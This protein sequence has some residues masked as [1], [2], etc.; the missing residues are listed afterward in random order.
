MLTLTLQVPLT[1]PLEAEVL[2]PDRLIGLTI[3][4]IQ[5]LPLRH[6]NR[7]VHLSDYFT[8]EGEPGDT[9][10]LHGDLSRVKWIGQ[11]MTQGTMQIHGSAGMHLGSGM[12]G[13]TITVQGNAADWT[14]AEMSGGLIRV[15]GNAGHRLGA[16]YTGSPAGMRGGT[17]VVHG[18]TG[19]ETGWQMQRG[20]ILLNGTAGDFTGARM[21]G[22]TIVLTSGAGKRT[23]AG[24]E[25][26]T[27]ISLT[28][29][30]RLPTFL[31]AC[32]YLPQ[33][34]G[35]YAR[36]CTTHGVHLPHRAGQYRRYAGDA[37]V[38]GKGELLIWEPELV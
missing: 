7:T 30:K 34:L 15:A 27:L 10:A 33:F 17:I 6:G 21:K 16:A 18:T 1:V 12:S 29:V 38:S 31:Y 25:R 28:T 19:D 5:Q 3:P 20:T 23:G 11:G 36:F 4:Q 35:L 26:G 22:G 13:G 9:L 2:S 8:V 32:A 14:G 37:A 24:M